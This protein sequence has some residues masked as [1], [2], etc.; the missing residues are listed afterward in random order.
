MFALFSQSQLFIV[1]FYIISYSVR[2]VL[3]KHIMKLRVLFGKTEIKLD[4]IVSNKSVGTVRL[5]AC[6][7]V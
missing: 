5:Y 1:L 4:S 7:I 2:L 3:I 6:F